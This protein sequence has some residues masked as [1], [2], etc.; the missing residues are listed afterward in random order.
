MPKIK[1]LLMPDYSTEYP[2]YLENVKGFKINYRSN[3]SMRFSYVLG[4]TSLMYYVH[5]YLKP[6]IV[7][8]LD[9]S[10]RGVNLTIYFYSANPN[11]VV[12]IEYW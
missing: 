5:N 2:I 4:G 12:E 7:R 9:H 8:N 3:F 11:Q 1:T 6:H 10:G